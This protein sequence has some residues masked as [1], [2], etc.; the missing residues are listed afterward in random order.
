MFLVFFISAK[1]SDVRILAFMS[2]V[3]NVNTILFEARHP[4]L[5]SGPHLQRDAEINSTWHFSK[6]VLTWQLVLYFFFFQIIYS[7]IRSM[8]VKHQEQLTPA[9]GVS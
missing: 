4:E 6:W 9:S 2:S 8:L 3:C 1:N 7:R 5:V